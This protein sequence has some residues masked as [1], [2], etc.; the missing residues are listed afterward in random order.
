MAQDCPFFLKVTT[1]L[2][3]HLADDDWQCPGFHKAIKQNKNRPSQ[4]IY[5]IILKGTALEW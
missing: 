5:Q 2:E 1:N 4:E 3:E